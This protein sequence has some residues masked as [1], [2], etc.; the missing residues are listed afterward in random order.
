MASREISFLQQIFPRA[1]AIKAF[2]SD[3]TPAKPRNE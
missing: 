2:I 1:Q 3:K